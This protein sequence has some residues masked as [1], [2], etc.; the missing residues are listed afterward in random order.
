MADPSPKEEVLNC[1]SQVRKLLAEPQPWS[2]VQRIQANSFLEYAEEQVA[3][4]LTVA[5]PRKEKA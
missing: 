3:T 5:R 4:R 1:L 2:M